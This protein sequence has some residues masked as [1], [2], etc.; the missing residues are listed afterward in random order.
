MELDILALNERIRGESA[1]VGDMLG[2]NFH[3]TPFT[4]EFDRVDRQVD[5]HPTDFLPVAVGR[6]QVVWY[7]ELKRR[8]LHSRFLL[9]GRTDVPHDVDHLRLLPPDAKDSRFELTHVEHVVDH[10][11]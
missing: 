4:T 5:N 6:R 8:L 3:S 9:Q 2:R 11:R 7:I 10:V 1:F